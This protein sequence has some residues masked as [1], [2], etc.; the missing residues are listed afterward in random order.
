MKCAL[1][2]TFGMVNSV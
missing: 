2:P 1:C